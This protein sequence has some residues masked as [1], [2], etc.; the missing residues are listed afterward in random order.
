MEYG[1]FS[2]GEIA[3][4]VP[5][6]TRFKEI[7]AWHTLSDEERAEHGWYP[8]TVN[9]SQKDQRLYLKLPGVA[10]FVDGHFEVTYDYTPKGLYQVMEER[11]ENLQSSYIAALNR[12]HFHKSRH[13]CTKDIPAIQEALRG[14]GSTIWFESGLVVEMERNEALVL[15][16]SLL[17]Y[18]QLCLKARYETQCQIKNS[19]SPEE[20]VEICINSRFD[21]MEYQA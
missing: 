13:F 10:T 20:I 9:D 11:L 17:D 2:G 19:T 14:Q 6:C 1:Y 15:L 5:M 4:P 8:C 16:Q 21:Q 3:A 7:G 18:K 12:Q